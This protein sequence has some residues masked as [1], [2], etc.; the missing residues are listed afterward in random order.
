MTTMTRSLVG[1]LSATLEDWE[2]NDSFFPQRVALELYKGLDTPISL[3]LYLRLKY[4]CLAEV[5]LKEISPS[6]YLTPE[7]YRLDYQAVSFLRKIPL[8]IRGLDPRAKALESFYEAERLCT[9]TNKRIRDMRRS[10]QNYEAKFHSILHRAAWICSSVLRDVDSD[11]LSL[12]RFGPGAD[13]SS[14]FGRVSSYNKLTVSPQCTADARNLV[15]AAINSLHGLKVAFGRDPYDGPQR[16]FLE[17]DIEVVR[18]N[19]ITF[20]PKSAKTDRCI[21][22]EPHM[23]IFLQLGVGGLIRKRLLKGMYIPSN[24]IKGQM[25]RVALN[26]DRGQDANRALAKVGSIDNSLCTVDMS[27]ASDT[28]SRE[29]VSELLPFSWF[30][31]MES[32]RSKTGVLDAA[33]EP[34]TYEKFSS[35]GNGFTFELETLIFWSLALACC[36]YLSIDPYDYKLQKQV[37]LAYGDDVVIPRDCFNLYSE[38]LTFCGFSL[39]KAKSFETGPFRESCGKDYFL[40]AEVRPYF[41]KEIPNGA[42]SIYRLANGLRR[43]ANRST[44]GFGCSSHFLP[45]WAFSVRR[46]PPTLRRLIVPPNL[47]EKDDGA[48]DDSSGLIG[49]FDEYLGT[50][51]RSVWNKDL[52]RPEFRSFGIRGEP[53][54]FF[55]KHVP[56]LFGV[57]L[58]ESRVGQQVKSISFLPNGRYVQTMR[59]EPTPKVR[60]LTFERTRWKD[61]GPWLA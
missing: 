59:G 43:A 30:S 47:F 40:G 4:D 19:R 61:L 55:W 5:V 27:M 54:R 57:V 15:H 8:K 52:H 1:S 49:N 58:Y 53:R 6:D 37:V 34:I 29:L 13:S 3:G 18:G 50:N 16:P 35:M 31:I 17:S 38:V 2:V 48:Y 45:A 41:L 22:I 25:I 9:V 28:V 32:L 26:L 7:R 33:S 44:G 10:P 23:N 24:L 46:L 36:D 21:A 20:V 12:S 42:Q 60:H 39:N 14:E 56:G 51:P 11:L